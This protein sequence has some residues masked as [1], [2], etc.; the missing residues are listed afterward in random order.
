M[1][2]QR[3]D[4][5]TGS[6][7][8]SVAWGYKWLVGCGGNR[9]RTM[10]FLNHFWPWKELNRLNE[11]VEFLKRT[12]EHEQTSHNITRASLQDHKLELIDHKS[13]NV[14]SQKD[15]RKLAT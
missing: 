5:R 8:W 15:I 14:Q 7:L 6:K 13:R 3:M 12:L 2:F 11:E 4:S 1:R 10:N 9:S